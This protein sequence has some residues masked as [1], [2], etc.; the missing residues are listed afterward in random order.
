MEVV[1]LQKFA[2]ACAPEDFW[3][4]NSYTGKVPELH[5]G[6]GRRPQAGNH[7]A[8]VAGDLAESGNGGF[9]KSPSIVK[10]TVVEGGWGKGIR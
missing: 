3:R 10:T 1:S 4:D 5:P 7:K 8:G 9:K 2:L 6:C